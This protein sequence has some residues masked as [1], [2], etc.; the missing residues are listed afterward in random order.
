[1]RI[2]DREGGLKPTLRLHSARGRGRE[3]SMNKL[4][5]SFCGADLTALPSGALWFAAE[6]LL[7][8]SDL[9]LGKS[10][11]IARRIG[12]MLPPYETR[13]TL[14]RLAMDI[15]AFDP[16]WVICLGDSFDDLEAAGSLDPE[17]QSSLLR[18]QA[19]RRWVWIAGNHDPGPV[20]LAGSHVAMLRAGPLVFRHEATA[21][22]EAEVSGHYHPKLSLPGMGR[23]R[24][25][26]LL[27]R[28]RLIL[29]AYG[30]YTG[31]LS[32]TAPVLQ[33]LM[34][35]RADVILTGARPV[36]MLMPRL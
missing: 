1:M 17:D 9:H 16:D 28:C 25:C 30:A 15:G 19:G 36:R 13:A 22:A 31:G 35:R 14:D 18:L 12:L 24:A 23:A 11:R 26:Y 34:Q 6:R 27:D 5:F 29:P 20:D 32:V 21:G 4:E 3:R 33:A 7:C 8:V 2:S 10:D